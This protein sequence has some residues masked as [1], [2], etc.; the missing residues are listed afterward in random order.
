MPT[1][2]IFSET[3]LRG[4]RQEGPGSVKVVGT[5]AGLEGLRVP[6]RSPLLVRD[7]LRGQ[8]SKGRATVANGLLHVHL[9]DHLGMVREGPPLGRRH[10]E[11]SRTAEPKVDSCSASGDLAGVLATRPRLPA[12]GFGFEFKGEDLLRSAK[13]MLHKAEGPDHWSCASWVLLPAAFWSAF[14]RLW[15]RVLVTGTVPQRWREGRV[16]LIE[17]PSQGYRPLTILSIA[18]RIGARVLVKQLTS[19]VERWASWR[20][21]GGVAHR[22]LKDSYLRLLES[23]SSPRFY[24]QEDLTKFFDS[25]RLP[26][27]VVVLRHLGCPTCVWWLVQSY[28]QD[29]RRVFSKDGMLGNRW[30]DIRRGLAQGCPLSPV[31][32]AAVMALW[33]SM[34]ESGPSQALSS[35]SFVDD[36]L[37]WSHTVEE[38]RRAKALSDQFDQAF[39]L[40]CDRKK[41]RFVHRDPSAEASTFAKELAY[42]ESDVLSVLGLCVPLDGSRPSLKDFSLKTVKVR[43]RLIGI[44]ARGLSKQARLL[45]TMVLPMLTWAGGFATIQHE[46]MEEIVGAFRHLLY[47]TLAHDTLLVLLY[48]LAGWEIHPQFACELAALREAV[49]LHSREPSWIEEASVRFAARRWP[50]LLPTTVTVLSSLGWAWDPRGS[51]ILRRDSYGRERRFELG[52]DSFEI[53]AE[54]LRDVFRRRFLSKCGR[55]VQQLHRDAGDDVAQGFSLPGPPQGCLAVFAGHRWTWQRERTP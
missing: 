12:L 3:L 41:S 6:K 18:W 25:V 27:L 21:L 29:H 4:I 1:V 42:E 36:R 13:S 51:Y 45:R 44:A 52:V 20:V 34:V 14:A 26:D 53:L 40:R 7:R 28:Y 9:I 50:D 17:K 16:V 35:M 55:V 49:R 23:L 54:W 33:S 39:D 30:H 37:L 48:E 11:V 8:R 31:L 43:I 46:E 38:L 32:A 15:Q 2:S 24:L 22:G 47:S 5:Q 19:W 10:R